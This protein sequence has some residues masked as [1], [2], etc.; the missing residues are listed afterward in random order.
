MYEQLKDTKLRYCKNCENNESAMKLS[1]PG[2]VPIR[3]V[4]I[5]SCPK[6]GEKIEIIDFPGDE[7]EFLTES[8]GN[9]DFLRAMIELRKTDI[10]SYYE[11]LTPY[12]KM[13]ENKLEQR[14]R[15]A[16]QEAEKRRAEKEASIPK[17]PT[18]GS[19]DIRKIGV[20]ERA[21]SIGFFGIF[22]KKINKTWKCQNCGHT[23]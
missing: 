18:C 22:S 7:F 6:C 19:K 2:Y 14:N 21:A 20:G 4:S 15:E 23:W 16:E 8:G 11:K 12:K 3:D 1:F 13:A 9:N 17:C 5:T 10:I